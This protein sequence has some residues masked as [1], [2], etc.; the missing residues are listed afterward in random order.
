MIHI[1][2]ETRRLLQRSARQ[3]F[4][5]RK[6]RRREARERAHQQLL[7]EIRRA[8]EQSPTEV[9]D[10]LQRGFLGE[11]PEMARRSLR[12]RT[13][14]LM[15]ASH[16]RVGRFLTEATRAFIRSDF[17]STII[18]S[19]SALEGALKQRLVRPGRK[20]RK[21]KLQEL[22]DLAKQYGKLTPAL[23]RKA[24]KVR[25]RGNTY[26]HT[27]GRTRRLEDR[28]LEVLSDTKTIL[29]HLFSG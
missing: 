14:L 5:E 11:L 12:L 2:E 16:Q 13:S 15:G 18:V 23:A 1:D 25:D 17:N 6:R 26:T 3:F 4:Q 28:A 21:K 7:E 8:D 29:E 22:I 24:H 19:R 20:I 9:M 27:R 10:A